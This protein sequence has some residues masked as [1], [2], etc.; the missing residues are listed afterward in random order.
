[1]GF[2]SFAVL[3]YYLIA[4]LSA[5]TLSTAENRPARWV[6]VVGALG[7]VV[8]GFSLPIGSVL[9]GLAVLALGAAVYGVRRNI[10]A[11]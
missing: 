1:I 8:V 10:P 5:A 6:P 2:S 11:G 3:A 4:N 9:A 7:C